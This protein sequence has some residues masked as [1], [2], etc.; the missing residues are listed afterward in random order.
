MSELLYTVAQPFRKRGK[1]VL[2][3]NEF[4]FALS[5]DLKWFSPDQ[6]RRVLSAAEEAGL[7]RRDGEKLRPLFNRSVEVPFGFKPG[8]DLLLKERDLFDRI[9]D[10]I[11]SISDTGKQDTVALVNQK[12]GDLHHM[13]SL[14][15]AALLVA[16]EKELDIGDLAREAYDELISGS[17]EDEVGQ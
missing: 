4:I 16:K 2:T 1:D 12:Q 5:L 6:A 11:V 7:L 10:R 14:E 13:V 17:S 3:V 9:I 15:V 8:P